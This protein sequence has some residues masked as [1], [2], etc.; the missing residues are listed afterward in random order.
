MVV[1]SHLFSLFNKSLGRGA[2]APRPQTV[3]EPLLCKSVAGVL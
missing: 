1:V 3:K 2:N